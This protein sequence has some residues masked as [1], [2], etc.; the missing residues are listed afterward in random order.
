MF[1]H[2]YRFLT[3]EESNLLSFKFFIWCLCSILLVQFVRGPKAV[4]TL[5]NSSVRSPRNIQSCR[6]RI[7]PVEIHPPEADADFLSTRLDAFTR[8]DTRSRAFPGLSDPAARAQPFVTDLSSL[9]PVFPP[10]P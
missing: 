7:F 5:I 4:L 8:V 6:G 3:P 10:P 9:R 1:P 2:P